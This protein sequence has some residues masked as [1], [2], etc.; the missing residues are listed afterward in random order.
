M[1]PGPTA[2]YRRSE[3]ESDTFTY[4][5]PED[6]SHEPLGHEL[7]L[8][9]KDEPEDWEEIVERGKIAAK[10]ALRK[11]ATDTIARLEKWQNAFSLT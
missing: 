2:T 7:G 10:G 6:I 11:L 3:E 5:L 9:V 1:S 4:H 8:R